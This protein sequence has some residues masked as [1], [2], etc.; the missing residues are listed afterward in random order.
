[1]KNSS[2]NSLVKERKINRIHSI[3]LKT[4]YRKKNGFWKA[5]Y[6]RRHGIFKKMGVDCYYLPS[7]LPSDAC[8]VAIHNNVRIACGVQFITHDIFSQMFNQNIRYQ[9]L[10][11]FTPHF[12]TIEV[13]DDVC[14]GGNVTIM[15]GVKI[16]P[17]AIVAGGA[18]VTKDVPEGAV[19][20]GNPAKVIGTVDDLVKKRI[21][22]PDIENWNSSRQELERFYW[23]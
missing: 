4:V 5:D 7:A 18:V 2:E 3:L 1:M 14:I 6:I 13:F 9:G 17:N 22:N 15:P 10:K 21:E 20:G 8:L 11:S 12:G 19:V 23:K 16:G